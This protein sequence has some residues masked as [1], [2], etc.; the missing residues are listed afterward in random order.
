MQLASEI[1]SILEDEGVLTDEV[2]DRLAALFAPPDVL[3][4]EATE[5]VPELNA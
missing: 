5:M 1:M 4:G 3:E 2:V